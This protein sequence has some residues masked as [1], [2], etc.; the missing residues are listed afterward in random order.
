MN[1]TT[2]AAGLIARPEIVALAIL[3]IGV[4][5]ARLASAATGGLLAALDRRSARLSTTD[6]SLISP[7]VIRVSRAFVFWAIV[8]IAVTQAMRALGVGGVSNLLATVFE[9]V[10]RLLVAASIVLAGHLLGVAASH[11]SARLSDSI[12]T[13]SAGPKLLYGAILTIAIVMGVQHINVDITFVA[14][15]LVILVG[16][17]S[18]GLMLAFGLGARQH[19][20]NLLARRE[21][22]RL[23]VGQRVRIDDFEGSVVA[24]YD[25]GVDVAGKGGVRYVP[26]ARLAESGFV[27]LHDTDGDDN[28]AA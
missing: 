17:V 15:L 13:E 4:I 25:T 1:E 26:A 16:T 6:A 11:L 21:L 28:D 14:Q 5:V 9:F 22:G 7:R 18:G 12:T 2:E 20:S 8:V 23:A 10:P 27:Y 24:I 3:V 19:V